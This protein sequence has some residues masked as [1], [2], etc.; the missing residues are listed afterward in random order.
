[1]ILIGYRGS[2]KTTVGRI[3]AE[4]LGLTFVDTDELV[5]AAAGRTIRDIFDH[6]GEPRFR[7]FESA[8]LVA[9]LT[10]PRTVIACGGGIVLSEAN[11]DALRQSGRPVIYL[12]AD[13][14]TLHARIHADAST[15]ANRPALT[16]LGG[17]IDEVRSLLKQREP[18]YRE[19]ATRSIGVSHMGV[20]EIAAAILTED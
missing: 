3:I 5:V 15:A 17:S 12:Q 8:A 7:E 18:L 6:D 11:R 14:A 19:A 16:P 9:A 2:G 1:M 10:M 4:R 20:E 13:A